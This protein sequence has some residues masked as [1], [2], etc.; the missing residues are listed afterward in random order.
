MKREA[1]FFGDRELVLVFMAKRLKEALAV[2]K[3]LDEAGFD[4][5][6]ETGHYQ[7][8]LLFRSERVGAFF[9]VAPE[10]ETNARLLLQ[11]NNFTPYEDKSS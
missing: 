7:S 6:I 2:E 10:D 8:G 4:Y 3:L 1:E 9:Y 11:K 5:A